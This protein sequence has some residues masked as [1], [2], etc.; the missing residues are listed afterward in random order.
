MTFERRQQIESLY[1]ATLEQA[2]DQRS[3]YLL[4]ACGND[5][6]L[7]R[8]VESL[9]AYEHEAEAFME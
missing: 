9:L 7:R 4:D 1:H 6:E 3:A 8:E 5:D 2:P